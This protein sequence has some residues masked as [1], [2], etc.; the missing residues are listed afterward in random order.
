MGD[1]PPTGG[2]PLSLLRFLGLDRDRS[3]ARSGAESETV[4]RIAARLERLEPEKARLLAAFAYVLA[5]IANADLEIDPE[6]TLEMERR[7]AAV[8]SLSEE[9]AALAVEIAKSQNRLLGGTENYVVTREFARIS[10][11]EQRLALLDCLFAVS[12]ADDEVSTAEDNE[13]RRIAEEFKLDHS[14]F[15]AAR[16]AYR[17]YLAVLKDRTPGDGNL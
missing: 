7:V 17:D 11:R 6:E 16:S 14:E 3:T 2:I 8:A 13:I 12:A 15:I 4:R 1:A 10:S 9:E 5:R